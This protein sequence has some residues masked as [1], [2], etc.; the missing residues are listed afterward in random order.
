MENALPQLLDDSPFSGPKRGTQYMQRMNIRKGRYTEQMAV[1][2]RI[3]PTT[4]PSFYIFD[5]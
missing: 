2:L 5:M 1:M 3:V 4:L